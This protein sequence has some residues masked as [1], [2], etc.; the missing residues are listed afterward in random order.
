[1]KKSLP[2]LGFATALAAIL[3]A[4]TFCGPKKKF[5]DRMTGTGLSLGGLSL[6][7]QPE[8]RRTKIGLKEIILGL[9]SAAALYGIFHAG[10]RISR[11]IVPNGGRQIE[12][13]YALKRIRPKKELMMRLGFIIGPAEEFFWRGFLQDGLMK[14]FGRV[15]GSLMAIAAYGGVHIASGNFMLVG[16]ATVA[17]AFWGGLYALGFPLGALIV[18][19]IAWDNIIFLIAPTTKLEE[20][21]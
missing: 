2:M 10:D 17:G 9:G 13:I 14:K 6:A 16:A 19:H 11:Q 4:L 18:S 8:L 5:W 3:F 7:T 15:W 21:K 1:M 20:E 12:D